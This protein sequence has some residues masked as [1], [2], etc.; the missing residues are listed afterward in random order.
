MVWFQTNFSKTTHLYIYIS[1]TF[2]HDFTCL[3]WCTD[4]PGPWASCR[5]N[6][7]VT[8]ADTLA[9]RKAQ[10]FALCWRFGDLTA[11]PRK[12]RGFLRLP[13]LSMYVSDSNWEGEEKSPAHMGCKGHQNWQPP[14]RMWSTSWEHTDDPETLSCNH[15]VECITIAE[16][17]HTGLLGF[18]F[19]F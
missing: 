4:S 17:G 1:S 3:I 6:T 8:E 19:F 5:A 15:L 2:M 9:F 14:R 7:L 13:Y 10:G 18:F 12:V 16:L 11:P